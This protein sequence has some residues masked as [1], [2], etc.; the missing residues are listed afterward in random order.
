M[1]HD[2]FIQFTDVRPDTG[3]LSEQHPCEAVSWGKI[4]PEELPIPKI[5]CCT[6]ARRFTV[7]DHVMKLKVSHVN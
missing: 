5:V 2:Y 3:G 4:D 6:I 7:A 1:G